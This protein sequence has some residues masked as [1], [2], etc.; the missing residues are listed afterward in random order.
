MKGGVRGNYSPRRFFFTA[1]F[2]C[3]SF[4]FSFSDLPTFFAL[5]WLGDLSAIMTPL[6][7]VVTVG[8]VEIEPCEPLPT[9]SFDAEGQLVHLEASSARLL[10]AR[11]LA[12]PRGRRVGNVDP[13]K[14]LQ[15]RRQ[16]LSDGAIACL[17]HCGLFSS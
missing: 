6:V 8:G 9:R 7:G 14:W 15:A 2:A 4:R 5:C 12:V 10:G 3:L 11:V 13:R 1:F 17:D 16:T